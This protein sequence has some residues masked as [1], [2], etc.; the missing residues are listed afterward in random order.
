MR[1]SQRELH[2]T[3]RYTI[4][5]LL[6]LM[7]GLVSTGAVQAQPP[8]LPTVIPGLPGN[9]ATAATGE[10]VSDQ[11]LGSVLF[12]NY[13]ISDSLSSSIN[14]RIS[15]TNTNPVQDITVHVFM[16][17]AW[18]CNTADFFLCLTRNQ[19]STF[20]VS[21]V[22]PNTAGYIVA[23]AVDSDG[24]PTSFNYLAGE[25]YAV[26]PTGHRYGLSAVAAARRDG[27]ASS[28][29]NSD[30]VSATIFFNG[31]QYDSLPQA[32]MLDSFPSQTSAP[33][34]SIGDSRM[35]IY[36]PASDLLNG[37]GR[38]AGTLF[39]LIF[40]DQENAFSGQVALNCYLASDKHRIS[41][42]RTAPNLSS[43]VPPGRTGWARFYAAGSMTVTSNT[44]GGTRN[45]DGAPL[46]GATATRIGSYNGGH[47]LRYLTSF[48]Q[49]FSIS[50][51][52][53]APDCGP[54]S[55]R[56]TDNGSSI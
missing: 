20:I 24:K 39:F 35:Y 11:K 15:I 55:F 49:G 7:A 38:F 2:T 53:I 14:T 23:V 44:T 9:A 21:D 46:L 29:I 51:P 10:V 3:L 12:F 17:D 25:E 27:L 30:G 52:V 13:Y 34:S 8:A 31:T 41:S 33:G 56:Q 16:V 37:S 47:N 19:T 6:V 42:I 40:D 5:S 22:D 18:T 32:L 4:L 1:I 26:T 28:P 43:I 48:A 50:I 45:L 54:A 36:S